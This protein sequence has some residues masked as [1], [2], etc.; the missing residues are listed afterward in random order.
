M[1]HL[2]I[3]ARAAYPNTAG[4]GLG[5]G[6]K[7]PRA[8]SRGMRINAGGL[9]FGLS[10]GLSSGIVFGLL[11]LFTAQLTTALGIGLGLGAG[12]M[13][14]L[15]HGLAAGPGDLAAAASPRAV[16]VRDQQATFL[17]RSL[18][19]PPPRRVMLRL[20]PRQRLG[21]AWE[22]RSRRAPRPARGLCHH[23]KR[24]GGGRC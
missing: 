10:F 18:F 3:R 21:G 7:N 14:G 8:P 1:R 5:P 11:S 23:G 6:K 19:L 15:A 20:M 17:L 4:L 12:Y 13:G 9:R 16:L 2:V 22:P 24:R